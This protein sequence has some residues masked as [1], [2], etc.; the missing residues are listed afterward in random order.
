[1]GV[2]QTTCRLG[3]R[4]LERCHINRTQP[5]EQG[6]LGRASGGSHRRLEGQRGMA[7]HELGSQRGLDWASGCEERSR[8]PGH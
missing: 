2:G 6:E 7:Q 4:D 8:T 5:A 3:S 1:M